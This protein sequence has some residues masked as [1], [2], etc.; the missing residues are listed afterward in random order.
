MTAQ[1]IIIA[2][3]I[4]AAHWGS[5]SKGLTGKKLKTK[6]TIRNASVTSLM[7]DPQPPKDQ[8]RSNNVSPRKRFHRMQPIETMYEN[9]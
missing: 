4:S 7:S 9:S 6:P 2:Q 1:N 3:F 5:P 8:R